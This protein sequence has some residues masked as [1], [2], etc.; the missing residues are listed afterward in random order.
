MANAKIEFKIGGVSFSGEGEETWLTSQLD[1]II[2]KAPELIKIAPIQLGTPEGTGGIGSTDKARKDAAI[3]AQT[4]PNYLKSN[5]AVKSQIQKFLATATWLH[6]KGAN[7]L[8]TGDVTKALRESNQSR[9]GNPSDCL[10]QNIKRGFIEKDGSQ[11]FVTD[12]G[13]A[14]LGI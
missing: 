14:S 5:N 9:L 2:D 11:F 6:A 8:S 7:R 4:L 13:R 10:A 3:A 12:E 1:K